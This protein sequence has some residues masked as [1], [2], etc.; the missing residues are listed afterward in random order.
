MSESTVSAE[1]EIHELPAPFMVVATQNPY[2]FEGTYFLPE[3]QLDRF[4]MR[5]NL[6]YP[7]PSDEA[8]ILHRQ[9]ALTSLKELTPVMDREGVL[10]LQKQVDEVRMDDSL[11]EYV[12][13]IARATRESDELQV[14]VSPRGALALSQAARATALLADRD[15]VVPD[16]IIA[17]ALP[18]CAHRIISRTYMHAGDTLTTRRIMQK[19]LDTVPGPV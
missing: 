17:N 12:I 19:V 6:G 13:A 4:L 1:G 14:G 5:I 11:V 16:D 10:H 18:V 3:N 8:R 9:P 2:E 15:F 7:A